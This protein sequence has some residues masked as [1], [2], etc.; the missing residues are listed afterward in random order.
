MIYLDSAATSLIKPASVERASLRALCTMASPGRG[1]HAPAKLASEEVFTCRERA[2]E[3]FNLD[4]PARVVFTMNATHALNIAINSL[5]EKGERVVISGFEHNSV[6]RPLNALNADICVAATRLF[7][8]SEALE[9]FEKALPGAKLCV[10]THV[11]NVFG[12]ILPIYE[13]GELCRAH[14]VPFIVDA[15]QSTGILD[16]NAARL[17]ADFIAMPGHK[18]LFGPQGTGILL[19]VTDRAKPLVYGGS[20]SDSI[21]QH[22]PRYLPDM[23]E[24]GTHNVCGIAGLRAGLEYIKCAGRENIIRH[25][26]AL[27]KLMKTELHGIEGLELF[28]GEEGTQCGVLSVRCDYINSEVFAQLLAERG[29]C[30]RAGLH[31]SP[32][33]HM[34][35]GTLESGTVRL[36]FSPF[37]TENEVK[38]AAEIIRD[39]L[40]REKKI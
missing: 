35:A 12:Y 15:S 7:D 31:C 29:V 4:D 3:L 18:A 11:S 33:A 25:E 28:T 38:K 30:V 14:N 40:R 23:L 2:A 21:E 16:V 20:G 32:R 9:S 17:N 36:S 24:A 5:C 19:C 1:G 26:N 13:I 10:C 8:P 22:M 34:S 37:I 6:T 27:L 39:T